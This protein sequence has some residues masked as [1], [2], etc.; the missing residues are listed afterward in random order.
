MTTSRI[1]LTT[2]WFSHGMKGRR[3]LMSHI[4]SGS[5]FVCGEKKSQVHGS[6]VWI[7]SY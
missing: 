5:S 3:F 2:G 1:G 4:E 7:R 6:E